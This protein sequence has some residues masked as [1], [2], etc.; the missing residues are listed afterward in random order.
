MGGGEV[1][2]HDANNNHTTLNHI[3]V[4]R[5]AKRLQTHPSK[6][7]VTGVLQCW[8]NEASSLD[9]IDKQI[10]KETQALILWSLI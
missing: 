6:H 7:I 3:Q 1:R 2:T 8:D 9:G 10:G 4:A 5:Y